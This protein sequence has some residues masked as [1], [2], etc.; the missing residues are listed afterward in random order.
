MLE[1]GSTVIEDKVYAS[2]LLKTLKS[3]SGEESLAKISLEAVKVG[4]LAQRQ[5]ILM[6]CDNLGQFLNNGWVV[7][8]ET[9]E[10]GE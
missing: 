9:S 10:A 6:V 8:V 1:E 5:L 7:N 3:A 2:E 4:S